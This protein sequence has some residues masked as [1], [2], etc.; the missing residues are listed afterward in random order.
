MFKKG[1]ALLLALTLMLSTATGVFATGG[2]SESEDTGGKYEVTNPQPV[3]E[4][5]LYM[6]KKLSDL[7]ENGE[8]TITLETYV[9]GSVRSSSTSTDIVL[10]LD[11]SGSMADRIQG[12]RETKLKMLR[13]SVASFVEQVKSA[14]EKI[15]DSSKKHRIAMVGFATAE[16]GI[17]WSDYTNTEILTVRSNNH[18][19]GVGYDKLDDNDY[20]SALVDP[21]DSIVSEAINALAANGATRTDYGMKMAKG[22]LDA[23]KDQS[24]NKVVVMFT[25]GE[26]TSGTSFETG[27]ANST[28]GEA[29]S[30]KDSGATVYSIL[31]ADAKPGEDTNQAKFMNYTSSNYPA[32]TSMKKPGNDGKWNGKYYNVATDG[33]ALSDIFDSISEDIQ[34]VALDEETVIKDVMSEYFDVDAKAA[35]DIKIYTSDYKGND[36][37][38]EKKEASGVI[39]KIE[40]GTVSVKGFDFEPVMDK[41]SDGEVSGKKLIIEIPVKL[42]QEAVKG[43]GGETVDSNNT[44]SDKAAIVNDGTTVGEFKTPTVTLPKE[45]IVI[46]ANSAKKTYDG[47]PLTDGGYTYTEGVLAEGD[48]LT[49]TVKGSITDAGETANEVVSYEVTRDGND[50]AKKYDI[51]VVDGLLQVEKRT[52]TLTGNS[53]TVEYTGKEQSV[54]GYEIT[55]GTLADGQI[56]DA[57]AIAKGTEAG[58]YTG[59][60]TVDSIKDASGNDVTENYEVKKVPGKL[61]IGKKSIVVEIIGNTNTVKYNGE[62]QSIAG[63]T[64]PG[65]PGGVTV[66]LKAGV[67]AEAA[68]TDA[69]EYAMGLTAEDF[70]VNSDNYEIA[71]VK[72]TDGW[73]KIEKLPVTIVVADAEKT[74]GDDDPEF[75]DEVMTGHIDGELTDLDLTVSRSD[76]EDDTLGTHEGVLN[77]SKAE[78]ELEDIYRNYDFAI[79]P[80]DFTVVENSAAL[81]VSAPDV[82][83]KYDGRAHGTEATAGVAGA[84]I[85]YMDENGQYTLDEC[86]ALT[87]VGTMTVKFQAELYGYKSATGEATITIQPRD[88]TLTSQSAEKVYDGKALAKADVVITGDGFVEGEVNDVKAI[89]TV[90]SVSEAANTIEF[91]E[92]ENFKA[93]NYNITREE[94]TLKVTPATLTV[95]ADDKT[96]KQG[97]ENPELTGTITGFVNDEKAE[98][99]VVGEAAYSTEAVKD[100]PAGQYEITAA[101]GTLQADNY[102]FQ[103]VNGTLTVTAAAPAPG[104]GD[105]QGDSGNGIKTGDDFSLM[106]LAGTG[107]TALAA[108]AALLLTRRRKSE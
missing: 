76:V 106:L 101:P 48:V 12:S 6:S 100:S 37:F 46:T 93:G 61:T 27:V 54:E 83:Q 82:T 104:S 1:I 24:R 60:I 98:D 26:P 77:I 53:D 94:G 7:D 64:T 59:T 67:K 22:I 102:V 30:I 78:E 3:N 62:K 35:G 8:G 32:A 21:S 4:E 31:L 79:T 57:S 15:T 19:V 38:G 99:V 29:K 72:Y 36:T 75:E 42:D 23:D 73:L 40:N 11:Q 65:L 17:I 20:T 43:H 28:I 81:I 87:D 44:D 69:G 58:T 66:E 16:R 92:G 88:V 2:G 52:I 56:L 91:T 55:E 71:D 25:D 39:A 51:V 9:K 33:T 107:L 47:T 13:T 34:S 89:G 85:K 41:D 95:T 49:A 105:D 10:V 63:F 80:G 97:E 18:G 108:A 96:K 68:G 5:G 45:K 50:V 74:Y 90:T 103:Y 14:N 86:P 84:T 70:N